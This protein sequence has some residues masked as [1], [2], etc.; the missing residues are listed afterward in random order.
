M[1][2]RQQ[3]EGLSG[4]NTNLCYQCSKCSAGCPMAEWMDLK[5]AQLMHSICLDQEGA[6]WVSAFNHGIFMRVLE[7]GTITHRIDLTD[8]HAV[9]CQLGG[10]DGRTLFCLTL[11]VLHCGFALSAFIHGLKQRYVANLHIGGSGI[12]V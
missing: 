11:E 9:A 4:Q 10:S 7:G 2:F 12:C 6:I 5:P 1:T 3:I 8:R